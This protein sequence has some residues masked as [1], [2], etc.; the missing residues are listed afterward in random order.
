MNK[1]LLPIIFLC[2][3]TPAVSETVG[4]LVEQQFSA[5]G[6]GNGEWSSTKQARHKCPEE[7]WFYQDISKA[8]SEQDLKDF[9]SRTGVSNSRTLQV[10]EMVLQGKEIPKDLKFKAQCLTKSSIN[11]VRG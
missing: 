9:S 7:I 11:Q 3:A 2:I 1:F 5:N 10:A 8:K 6:W 4:S